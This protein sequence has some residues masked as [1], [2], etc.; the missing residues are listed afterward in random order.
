MNI[1][2][3]S[4][5]IIVLGRQNESTR[6]LYN[7]LSINHHVSCVIVER[8][9]AKLNFVKRRIKKLGFL[10]VLDQ[11]LFIIFCSKVLEFFSR[12]R[13]SE[14][15]KE[16]DISLNSIPEGKIVNVDSVNSQEVIDILQGRNSDLIVLSGTRILANKVICSTNSLI[17]NIHAGITPNYRGVHG[18]YWALVNN[19]K[20][21]AGVTLHVVDSGVDTGSIIDQDLIT[22]TKKDNYS[23]YPYLQLLIGVN[24][25]LKYLEYNSLKEYDR[26]VIGGDG[27][28]KQWFHPGLSQYLRNLF[29]LGVR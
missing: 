15:L 14:I 12:K 7:S 5:N 21:L 26:K 10:R 22:I 1:F 25:L 23:T 16:N 29:V 24:L 13:I 27:F 20:H 17:L 19:E 28:S 3:E 6:I 11:L 9:E 8:G 2:M 18:A 4:K